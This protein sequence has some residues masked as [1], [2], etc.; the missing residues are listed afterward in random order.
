MEVCERKYKK[1]R[2]GTDFITA[3]TIES[4]IEICEIMLDQALAMRAKIISLISEGRG[5]RIEII[6]YISQLE[7]LDDSISSLELKIQILKSSIATNKCLKFVH[8]KRR[9][10]KYGPKRS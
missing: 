2:Y 4:E 6:D 5:S 1:V 8:R 3:S 7:E 9:G 10:A